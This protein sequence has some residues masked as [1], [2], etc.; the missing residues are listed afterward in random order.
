MEGGWS[1][2]RQKHREFQWLP[3]FFRSQWV[4]SLTFKVLRTRPRLNT[5]FQKLYVYTFVCVHARAH[6]TQ[7]LVF[8]Q[9]YF[10]EW[11]SC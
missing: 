8:V 3:W 1:E 10:T 4:P 7:D 5:L 2:G 9:K 11:A 6:T